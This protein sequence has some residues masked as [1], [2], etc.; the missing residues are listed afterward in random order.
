[1]NSAS[2]TF[3]RARSFVHLRSTHF[4]ESWSTHLQGKFKILTVRITAIY[5]CELP[6]LP[7]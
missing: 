2:S 1:M 4:Q 3:G 7:L 5:P 6:G